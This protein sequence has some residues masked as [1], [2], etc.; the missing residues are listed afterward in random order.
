VRI[1]VSEILDVI[2]VSRQVALA[3]DG[4]RQP[5]SSDPQQQRR[6]PRRFNPKHVRQINSALLSLFETLVEVRKVGKNRKRAIQRVHVLDSFGY[7]YR[8]NGRELDV[9]HLPPDRQKVNVGSNNRPVYRVRRKTGDDEQFDRPSGI[10]YR[11]NTELAN[12]LSGKP[13]TLQF[14]IVARKV[15][16]T[17]KKF[18]NNPAAIRLII[19]VLRQTGADFSRDLRRTLSDLGYDVSHPTRAF[20]QIEGTLTQLKMMR[21]IVDFAVEPGTNRLF[22]SRNVGWYLENSDPS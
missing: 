8:S 15:F 3:V 18:M 10:L 1:K 11:L 16:L 13:D 22:I 17:L 21:L 6:H 2:A 4:K 20:E 5:E 9:D 19:L 14:T 7:L 12:E